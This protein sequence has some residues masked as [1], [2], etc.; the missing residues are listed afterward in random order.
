MR[1]RQL[2]PIA[3]QIF[4]RRKSKF[5]SFT[6]T[7]AIGSVAL[8]S[9]ALLLALSILDGFD[10]ELQS[11]TTLFIGH[12]DAR[13]SVADVQHNLQRWTDQLARTS[14]NIANI[15]SYTEIE[16]LLTSKG[17]VEAVLVHADTPAVTNRLN[18]L[19]INPDVMTRASSIALGR[20]LAERLGVERGDTIVIMVARGPMTMTTLAGAPIPAVRR[21]VVEAIYESGLRQFDETIVLAGP[22]LV[23]ALIGDRSTPSGFT[24]WLD[25]ADRSRFIAQR[26]DSLYG[27]ALYVRTYK[28]MHPAMFTWIALQK[29]PIP[30]I[31]GI[32]SIVAAF[33]IL[34]LLFVAIVERRHAVAVLRILGLDRR[35]VVLLVASYGAWIGIIGYVAGLVIGLAAGFAQQTFGVIQLDAEIYFLNR[36]P[37]H[38]ALWHVIVVGSV[39]IG[40]SL[41]VTMLPGYAATR[42]SPLTILRIK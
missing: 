7:I 42:I 34:T 29:R 13:I 3:Q 11:K 27:H 31:V 9:A 15:A 8:S 30:I 16:A 36:L 35:S 32:L 2:F 18:A 37:I 6:H 5:L 26:L 20:P 4:Y 17:N 39:T 1:L 23:R 10:R 38:F 24:I 40:L 33:N 19:G 14:R 25:D 41:L 28:D 12:I 21:V 22:L